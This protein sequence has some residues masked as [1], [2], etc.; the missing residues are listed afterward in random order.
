[1]FLHTFSVIARCRETG[2]FGAAVA[3]H[4]PGVGAYAPYVRSGVGAMVVQGWVNPSF[5][6]QGMDLLERGMCSEEVLERLLFRDPGRE[7]RQLAI[8]DRN[9]TVAVHTGAENDQVR[10]HLL[11]KE[12]VV[13]G[14]CLATEAVLSAM[15]EA[16][17]R[18]T[19]PLAERL[20]AALAAGDLQG[21]DR[22][23]KQSAAVRVVALAGF[24]YVDFRVD[25]HPD[26]VLE[27]SRI[28]RENK[29]L[30]IDRYDE[31]VEAVRNGV[32][33]PKSS[34]PLAPFSSTAISFLKPETGTSARSG[35]ARLPD[36]STEGEI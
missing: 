18:S 29:G 31:W 23:G 10:G 13:V 33:F 14:N 12:F 2:R 17:Y 32:P 5:G 11:G 22:R 34:S 36:R 20:L 7:L 35:P 3:S 15:A 28:Y 26:P 19:G 27:L 1:M 8:I 21:G 25:Y 16:F 24:P 4:F 30:L 6:L 9:G